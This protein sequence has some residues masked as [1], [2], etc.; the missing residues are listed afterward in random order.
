MSKTYEDGL[1]DAWELVRKLIYGESEYERAYSIKDINAIFGKRG[2]LK[3]LKDYTASE[4]IVKVKEYEE[5]Q[6]QADDEIKV[7][8][9]IERIKGNN[10]RKY[11]VT[12]IIESDYINIIF[13]DGGVGYVNPI[14]YRKTGRHFSQIEEVLKQMKD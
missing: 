8:D 11:I 9:E 12:K 1:N 5:K 6:K 7:G 4:A 14:H 13:D 3:I 10:G 2:Y